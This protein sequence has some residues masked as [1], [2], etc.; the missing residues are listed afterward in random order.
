[1]QF[2]HSSFVIIIIRTN[3]NNYKASSQHLIVFPSF[4]ILC[5]LHKIDIKL[6]HSMNDVRLGWSQMM[7]SRNSN[8][9]YAAASTGVGFEQKLKGTKNRLFFRYFNY[10]SQYL[11]VQCMHNARRKKNTIVLMKKCQKITILF[12]FSQFSI[13]PSMTS[14]IRLD[15]TSSTHGACLFHSQTANRQ[16]IKV[17][18]K[19]ETT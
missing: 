3:D 11:S 14:D 19:K 17:K 1:M 9:P 16:G 2:L 5:E 13:I 6:I 7:R 10:L 12:M 18:K 4:S 15:F 8:G